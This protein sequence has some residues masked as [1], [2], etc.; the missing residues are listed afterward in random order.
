MGAPNPWAG[1]PAPS[2]T[3][4]PGNSNWNSNVKK[5]SPEIRKEDVNILCKNLALLSFQRTVIF[6]SHIFETM[7]E[8][9]KI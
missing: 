7:P 3:G 6:I 5:K 4:A 1:F 2:P 9:I 8:A